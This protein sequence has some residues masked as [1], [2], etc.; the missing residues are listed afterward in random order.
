MKKDI[1]TEI[2]ENRTADMARLGV[3]F[4]CNVPKTRMR[5]V[6]PF[7]TEKGVILEV[8]RASPSKGDIAVNLDAAKTAVSYAKAGAAAI[9]C[10]TESNYFKGNLN[11]LMSVCAAVDEIAADADKENFAG[12]KNCLSGGKNSSAASDDSAG[13]F[14]PAVLR[15]DFLINAEEVEVSYRAGADAVLLIA[16]IL[17]DKTIVK[18]AE[19]AASLKMTSLIEVR[20]DDDL[21]KLSLVAESVEK[22]FIVCGVNSRDLATFKIDLLRPLSMLSRIKAILGSKARTVFESGIRTCESAAFAGSLG[23]TGMLLGEAAA[24]NPEIRKNLVKSFVESKETKNGDFWNQIS[25]Q[26]LDLQIKKRPLVKICGITNEED[27]IKA[28]ELGADFLGFIFYKKSP[29][30]ANE[31]VVRAVKNQLKKIGNTKIKLIGV[32]VEQES[33]ESKTAV[34]LAKN[35]VLDALQLHTI[36]CA[37]EF[38]SSKENRELPHYAAVNISCEKDV[39]ILDELFNLG[40]P[41]ILVDAQ[42][43][44]AVGG[45]GKRIDG[46]LLN[47]IKKRHNLWLA[48]GI[49]AENV[50][51][52]LNDFEPE[53][54]DVASGVEKEPGIKDEERL[55]AL[56]E[57]LEKK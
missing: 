6:H 23:F 45:S 54:I 28:A 38:L 27:G 49:N 55:E 3:E 57:N 43:E 16:R 22:K 42:T 32:I 11:D 47:L 51:Q 9:S 30:N 25:A 18:M 34:N 36:K 4:G 46:N 37:K 14:I 40:E 31:N 12:G 50:N 1:L 8:K 2:V 29:R 48:G 33:Y 52:I 15:K 35:G 21:R 56:F 7:L 41:R 20:T 19:T 13:N 26:V 17:D 44:N 10:L 5:K 39:E 24:K 53:L